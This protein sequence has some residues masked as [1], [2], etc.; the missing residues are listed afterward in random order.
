M[1]NE[2][3]DC[4]TSRKLFRCLLTFWY[5]ISGVTSGSALIPSLRHADLKKTS[6]L[7]YLNMPE[8]NKE[9]KLATIGLGRHRDK[10]QAS[11]KLR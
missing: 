3:Q 5:Y 1:A 10:F 2:C 8:D 9:W 11:D 7:D 6:N 4:M